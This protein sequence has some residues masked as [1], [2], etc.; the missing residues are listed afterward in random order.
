MA[1]QEKEDGSG[2]LM[3]GAIYDSDLNIDGVNDTPLLRDFIHE[4]EQE[5]SETVEGY[6]LDVYLTGNTAIMY[7]MSTGAAQDI[8]RIDPFTILLILVLVGLFFR[9][10]ITS[11]TP[12][13]SLIHISEP[14][15]RS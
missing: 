6:D 4:I 8:S 2:I 13:L 3:V 15:R 12:P 9:S 5:Y 7:D 14:T 1:P 10:F 11:A